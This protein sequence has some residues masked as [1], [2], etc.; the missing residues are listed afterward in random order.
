M[1]RTLTSPLQVARLALFSDQAWLLYV[2]ITRA[3]GGY[4][5]LV[6]SQRHQTTTDGR[7]WQACAIDIVLPE[8]D[9]EGSLGDLR[10]TL[11]NV[12]R[13]PG[14][15]IENG[16]ILNQRVTC[17]LGLEGQALSPALSWTHR[18]GAARVRAR[19]V[20]LTCD[21]PANQQTVPRGRFDRQSFPELLP[22][23]RIRL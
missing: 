20:T 19:T 5:R 13:V 21:H 14:A 2:E 6:R 10:L 17:Y 16:D 18:V 11:P 4:F 22:Q 9:A 1:P 8:E 7:V 12:S 15:Y 3:A 23:G